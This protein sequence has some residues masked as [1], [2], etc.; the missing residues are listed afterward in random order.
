MLL[1]PLIMS[2]FQSQA[3]GV[4][5]EH[6]PPCNALLW[7]K[8]MTGAALD[9]DYKA[10]NTCQPILKLL[11]FLGENRNTEQVGHQSKMLTQ[12]ATKVSNV[13]YVPVHIYPMREYWHKL[14]CLNQ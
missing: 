11:F 5:F 2:I 8:A 6:Y 9:S 3:L 4:P 10:T 1:I 12:P 7:E 13:K 14:N